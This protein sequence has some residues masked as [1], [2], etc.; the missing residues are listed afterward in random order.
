MPNNVSVGS[1]EED[2]DSQSNC[3]EDQKNATCVKDITNPMPSDDWV[4]KARVVKKGNIINHRN[5]RLFK[6]ELDD[7][8]GP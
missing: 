1:E 5:G 8:S 2:K 7:A 4:I 3:K 6:I